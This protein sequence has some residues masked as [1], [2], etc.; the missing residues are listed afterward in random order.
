MHDQRG[1]TG[2]GNRLD[3]RREE[4][5]IVACIDADAAFDRHRYRDRVA[6]TRDA[7]RH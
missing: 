7:L 5:I 4:L 1:N 3:E 2:S 6:H